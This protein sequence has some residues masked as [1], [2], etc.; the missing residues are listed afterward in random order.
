MRKIIT[1]DMAKDILSR[2]SQNR[3]VNK[4]L[5][6]FIKT[7]INTGQFVY[8]GQSITVSSS[9]ILLDGQHRLHACVETNK[10]IEVEFID[11]VDSSVFGTIDIGR[12][13]TSADVF[14]INGIEK[15]K[16]MAS[17]CNLTMTKLDLDREKRGTISVKYSPDEI[18]VFFRKHEEIIVKYYS[19][20][21]PFRSKQKL[22]PLPRVVAMALILDIEDTRGG[23]SY[24]RQ[25]LTGVAETES[26]VPF[27]IREKLIKNALSVR[28][29]LSP[30]Y[31][32][33]MI[34]NSFYTYRQNKIVSKLSP[35]CGN[36]PARGTLF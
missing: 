9:G 11:G 10:D 31:I 30:N 23:M 18:L 21:S 13:R 32:R 26:N 5:L 7:Q 17:I 3:V 15:S 28:T 20:I 36:L 19:T 27:I 35:Q 2:N 1:P 8:N 25:I 14:S 33:N 24:I 22:I 29:S 6:E 4:S 16:H 12:N 34:L